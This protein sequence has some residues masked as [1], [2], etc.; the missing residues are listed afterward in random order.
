[1]ACFRGERGDEHKIVEQNFGIRDR[2]ADRAGRRK[3]IGDFSNNSVVLPETRGCWPGL[4]HAYGSNYCRRA[5]QTSK[6]TC[7]H[8]KRD[9]VQMSGWVHEERRRTFRRHW[10]K[11]QGPFA[12]VAEFR[13]QDADRT[14]QNEIGPR[15]RDFERI[16]GAY[17]DWPADAQPA[18]SI[19]RNPK[20]VRIPG[21]IRS[22]R[23][24]GKTIE[25][26]GGRRWGVVRNIRAVTTKLSKSASSASCT[27][28]PTDPGGERL[29][30][31]LPTRRSF[32]Q[33]KLNRLRVRPGHETIA[34]S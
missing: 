34:Y 22:E 2:H 20:I 8:L 9:I 33:M 27:T 3:C 7:D 12:A 4:P 21:P 28:T 6:K 24:P 14:S 18:Q 19:I 10:D 16:Q 32:T 11:D 17:R 29:S 15:V 23:F 5:T 25:P 30:V 31:M 26:G 13:P 1:M